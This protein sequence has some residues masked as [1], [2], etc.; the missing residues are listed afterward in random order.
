MDKGARVRI[1]GGRN[2]VG[3]AGEIFWKGPNKWGKG[4]RFG[5][6]GD[7]GETY[8]VSESDVEASEGPA[9][10]PEPGPTFSKG[11]RVAFRA[12][13]REGTGSV[14]WIGENKRGPGQRLG[15]R[16]DAPEG[17]DDAVWIDAR[18]AR[19]LEG[20]SSAPGSPAS[21]DDPAADEEIPPAAAYDMPPVSDG[22]VRDDSWVDSMSSTAEAWDEQVESWPED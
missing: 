15:I 17:E 9:P 2:G 16:D 19:P 4:D 22:P 10:E 6:R 1:T 11:D 12:G 21:W 13:G 18:F 7:D 3:V 14:F 20:E 8:W 5:I